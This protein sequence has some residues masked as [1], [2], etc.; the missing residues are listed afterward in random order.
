M[1]AREFLSEKTQDKIP[2]KNKSTMKGVYTTPEAN[3][4]A[5]D[6]YVNYRMG[7]ALAG[8]PDYPT[9]AESEIGGDPFYH[10]YT[11]EEAEMVHVAAKVVGT[12]V[13]TLNGQKSV[14]PDGTYTRSP[15]AAPKR[16]RYGV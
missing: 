12:P 3:L 1:R 8:A 16:N 6:A 5:G 15:V 10:T 2:K 14:E 9:A 7:L 4:N 11:D 13:R